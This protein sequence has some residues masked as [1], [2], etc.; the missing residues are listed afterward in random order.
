M[1]RAETFR[2]RYTG[3]NPRLIGTTGWAKRCFRAWKYH[4]DGDSRRYRYWLTSRNEFEVIEGPA[5][6]HRFSLRLIQGGLP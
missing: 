4:V 6:H 2:V 5:Q 1:S 3:T